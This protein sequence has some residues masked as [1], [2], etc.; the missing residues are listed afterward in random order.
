MSSPP[1]KLSIKIIA[2]VVLL[3]LPVSVFA[4]KSKTKSKTAT[5]K[6]P[7]VKKTSSNKNSRADAAKAAAAKKAEEA[8]RRAADE[9]RRKREQAA[10][11]AQARRLAFERGLRT[12]TVENISVDVT[13]GEDLEVRRAAV[14]ALGSKAGTVVVLEPQTGK[15]LTIVNQD[16]GVRQS[17][18]P[19][20]VIK[21]VTSVAGINE[22][23]ITPDGGVSGSNIAIGLDDALAYSN[24]AYFQRV[25]VSVGNEK[26]I[27]YAKFLGLGSPTGIN[28][29]GETAGRLPYGNGNARIYSHG[30]DFQVTPL[31]LAVL[32]SALSN[33]GRIIIPQLPRAGYEKAAFRGSYKRLVDLPG[34]TLQTVLP[35]MIGA[36]A[37][38]TA[39]NGVDAS[40]GIAGKTG[41]CIGQGTWLGLFA[42]VAPVRN[43]RLAVV[44]ITRGQSE[45]GKY[46]AGVAGKIYNALRSRL[47]QRVGT[48]P[49]AKV[50]TEP[51]PKPKVDA[52]TSLK[53]DDARTEDSDDEIGTLRKGKKGSE[54]TPNPKKPAPKAGQELFPTIVITPKSQEITRPRIVTRN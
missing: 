29:P 1:R 20:S 50:T 36:A 48:T 21:L 32:V 31:Q 19:C 12:S 34:S 10:R 14:E 2:A 17:F 27:N 7:L 33:G 13:D 54:D 18:K 30:D 23:V 37:Y 45:R 39:R 51:K 46:A 3:L 35:G 43:P 26:M 16:W 40:L 44:V 38:G 47:T 24:N 4:Q 52:K 49:L 8:R 53:L 22:N 42:S 41:S 15:V 11:E 6:A 25:G 28:L 9:V 5:K